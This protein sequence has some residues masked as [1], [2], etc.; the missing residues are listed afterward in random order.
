MFAVLNQ[1]NRGEDQADEVDE[2]SLLSEEQQAVID[3]LRQLERDLDARVA[4]VGIC[5]K[6]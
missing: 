1:V 6:P 5:N 2:Q 4:Q 3:G